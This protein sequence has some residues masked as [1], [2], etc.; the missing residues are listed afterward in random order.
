[1]KFHLIG[2]G[3]AGM[4]VVAE[5]LLAEGHEVSGSDR[6]ESANLNRLHAMGVKTFVGH[7]AD[8][9]PPDAVVVV[10][11]AIKPENLELQIAQIRGQ[12]I[13][14]RSQALVLAAKERDFVAVAGAHGKT[15][16]TGI[17]AMAFQE[18]GWQPS[19]AIG[20]SLVGGQSGGHLGSGSVLVAEADESD[21]SFLNYRSRV[22]IVTSVEP[23]HLDYY[24][25]P[26]AFAEAFAQFAKRLVPGGLLV[27]NAD[28]PGSAHL[29]QQSRAAGIRVH[30]YGISPAELGAEDRHAQ[31]TLPPASNAP[32]EISFAGRQY[33]LQLKVP[34][35]HNYFNATAAWLAGVELGADGSEMAH[36]LTAFRGMQRRFEL[37]GTVAGIRVIDDYAHHPTEVSATLK[38]A[39]T[40]A[41]HV[42]VL[43]QPHLYSRTK[44]FAKEFAEALSAADSVIVTAVYPAREEPSAGA[45]GDAITACLPEA[46]FIA[47]ADEA[48]KQIAHTAEPGDI[49]I[50]MGAGDITGYAPIVLTELKKWEAK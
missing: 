48:A 23:D 18:L 9:V 8:H 7:H 32:A 14:H 31:L 42:R 41:P 37:R 33:S 36:A 28:H 20:G 5:L 26:A 19:W 22:A 3:G 30:T 21:G 13:L 24:G 46:E 43:F 44:A 45:E 17:L 40:L 29:A 16:T 50:T 49:V 4:S 11:S 47:S 35:E 38:T 25:T 2:V 34:G 12:K 27:C 10:S 1:M 6:A 15:S 39:R